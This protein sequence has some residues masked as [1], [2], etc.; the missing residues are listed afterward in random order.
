MKMQS[1]DPCYSVHCSLHYFLGRQ[2]REKV[3]AFSLYNHVVGDV[4]S[5]SAYFKAY[6]IELDA[7][8]YSTGVIGRLY[9]VR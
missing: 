3:H 2:G 6:G 7:R 4:T 5:N 9:F 1:A 8:K